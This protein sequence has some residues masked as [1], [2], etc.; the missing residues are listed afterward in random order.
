M[1]G[2]DS[3]MP[4]L[5]ISDDYLIFD[6]LQTV[7]ITNPD[8]RSLVVANCL[9]QGVDNILTDLGDGSLGY[10]TF[11]TWHMWRKPLT[12]AAAA[13]IKWSTDGK[14]KWNNNGYLGWMSSVLV[15]QLNCKIVDSRGVAWWASAV[16]LDVWGNKYQIEA[17]AES[18]TLQQEIILP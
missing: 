17:E 5:D 10:R 16:N 9:M 1:Q 3:L 18:G 11:T 14:I 12:M 13:G 15:P 8:G 6:N 7:T 4:T 2:A